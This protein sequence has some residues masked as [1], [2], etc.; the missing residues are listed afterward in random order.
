MK[1]RRSKLNYDKIH[2]TRWLM[3]AIQESCKAAW[4][5]RKNLTIEEMMIRYKD[6]HNPI[7]QYIPNKPQKWGLKVWC[8]ACSVSKYVWNFEFYCG[9]Q[10]PPPQ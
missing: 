7:C 8:L 6:T 9:R 3:D 1:Y 4:N 2:Q 5:L 10:D